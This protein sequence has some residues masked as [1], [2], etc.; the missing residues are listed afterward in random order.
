MALQAL[1]CRR[2]GKECA[3][4]SLAVVL[5]VATAGRDACALLQ[6]SEIAAV[7]GEA[8][9]EM[10][11]SEREEGALRISDCVFVLP[12][13]SRSISLE[14]IRGDGAR[15]RWREMFHSR[16]ESE[17]AERKALE[18]EA[19]PGLGDEAFWIPEVPS[20]ALYA[21]RKKA[22]LRISIGGKDPRHAKI[23]RASALLRKALR[24]L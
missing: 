7:Q 1:R 21:L 11:P 9:R 18:P 2:R 14:V 23:A 16:A 20:G 6:A 12:S 5:A 24:R 22:I 3:M 13:F 15:G 19:V 17:E 4:I 8:P 10:K